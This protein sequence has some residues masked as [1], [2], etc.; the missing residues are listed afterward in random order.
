MVAFD[1]EYDEHMGSTVDVVF[2]YVPS[3]PLEDASATV[4]VVAGGSLG[5]SAET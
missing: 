3:S 4:E 5:S 2:E 1:D